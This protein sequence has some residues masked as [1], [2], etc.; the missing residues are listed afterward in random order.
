MCVDSV[1]WDDLND[2]SSCRWSRFETAKRPVWFQITA[3]NQCVKFG[4]ILDWEAQNQLLFSK[5]GYVP[6]SGTYFLDSPSFACPPFIILFM[7]KSPQPYIYIFFFIK[8]RLF[9]FYSFHSSQILPVKKHR[10]ENERQKWR[11]AESLRGEGGPIKS[12]L[13]LQRRRPE[14]EGDER[15]K[16]ETAL[17]TF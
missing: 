2:L 4:L 1:H 16:T 12:P 17:Y 8:T 7:P 9:L 13:F 5:T 11:G 6:H 10:R 3:A 14:M 15:S